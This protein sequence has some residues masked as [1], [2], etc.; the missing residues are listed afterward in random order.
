MIDIEIDTRQLD[1]ALD[2]LERLPTRAF[3]QGLA[4]AAFKQTHKRFD[5]KTD[6]DGRAWKPWSARYRK[7]G[8][9]FHSR[10][11]MLHL[12]GDMQNAIEIGQVSDSRAVLQVEGIPYAVRQNS[13]RQFIGFADNDPEL[14]AAAVDLLIREVR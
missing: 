4:D 7:R 3:M 11:T 5:T 6:P 2:R 8:A 13:S 14:R 1:A 9:P 12:S 10:H